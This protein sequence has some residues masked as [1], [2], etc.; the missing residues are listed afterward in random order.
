VTV[1]FADPEPSGLSTMLGQLIAQNLSRDPSRRRLL[2]PAVVTIRSTDA[3]VTVSLS[4]SGDGVAVS[5]GDAPGAN[6]RVRAESVALLRLAASPLML[7]LPS[8]FDSRGRS[9]LFDIGRRRIRVRGL[10]R[11]L[12][13]V[14][15]LTMLLSAT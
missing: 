12:P 14:R 8:P 4:F 11:N 1:T 5:N 3:D 6:V 9:V 7:G 15:R 10:V 13:T 2:R